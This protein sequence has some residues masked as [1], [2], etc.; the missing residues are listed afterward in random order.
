[1][2]V[3]SCGEAAGANCSLKLSLTVKETI[4]GGKVIAITTRARPK[5]KVVVLGT[6]TVTVAAGQTEIIR[7]SLNRAGKR[8]LSHTHTLKVKLEV[9]QFRRAVFRTTLTFKTKPKRKH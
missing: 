1:M 2:V 8:L 6:R 9:T 3:V 7:I 4:N 5:K